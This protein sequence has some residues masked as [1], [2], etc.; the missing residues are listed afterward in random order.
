MNDIS[1]PSIS[2]L[3]VRGKKGARKVALGDATNVDSGVGLGVSVSKGRQPPLMSNHSTNYPKSGGSSQHQYQGRQG[4]DGGT[5]GK[6][7]A[8]YRDVP[9]LPPPGM[10]S[11]QQM[12]LMQELPDY[13][14]PTYSL[15][16]MYRDTSK[17]SPLQMEPYAAT[18]EFL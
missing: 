3:N 6:I 2:T 10:P 15:Y 12:K 11:L 8:Q 17:V 13:R 4:E 7:Q 18:A 5:R 1:S 16:G 9:P 14:S